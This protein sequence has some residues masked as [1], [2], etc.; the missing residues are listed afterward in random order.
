VTEDMYYEI[1][2]DQLIFLDFIIHTYLWYLVKITFHGSA[3]IRVIMKYALANAVGFTVLLLTPYVPFPCK[4]V[5]QCFVLDMICICRLFQEKNLSVHCQAYI[6]M[7]GYALMLGGC[8]L[9]FHRLFSK[10]ITGSRSKILFLEMVIFATVFLVI[11][12]WYLLRSENQ[13]RIRS[14]ILEVQMDFYGHPFSCMGLY[15]SGNCL[16][17]P[18]TKRAVMIV[19]K[20]AVEHFLEFVPQEKYYVIPFHSIGKEKGV[21]LAVEIPLMTLKKGT[22][23]LSHQKVLIGL[24]KQ[25]IS[26]N[27]TAIVHPAFWEKSEQNMQTE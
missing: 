20:E 25:C 11:M 1:Y 7:Q 21:L 14:C 15:D 6:M 5:L 13:K 23:L 9:A 26:S 2:V 27:Y 3:G 12:K 16:Y 19:E 8:I 4:I 22:Q 24:S 18:C 17:E 10:I